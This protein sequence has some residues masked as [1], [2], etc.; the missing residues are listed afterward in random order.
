MDRKLFPLLMVEF[1]KYYIV[2]D[3][4]KCIFGIT[5]N[6]INKKTDNDYSKLE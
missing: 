1:E 6:H 4:F 5:V 3:N 2:F